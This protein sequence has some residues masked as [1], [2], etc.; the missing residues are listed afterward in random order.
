[1]KNGCMEIKKKK[2]NRRKIKSKKIKNT[3][4]DNYVKNMNNLQIINRLI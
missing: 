4:V 3:N 2:D 1:M